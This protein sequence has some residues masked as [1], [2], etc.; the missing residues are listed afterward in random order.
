MKTE[1]EYKQEIEKLGKIILDLNEK[2]HQK[3]IELDSLYWVWCSGGCGGGVHRYKHSETLTE[4][5]VK[6]AEWNTKRLRTWWTN[7]YIDRHMSEIDNIRIAIRV[8]KGKQQKKL[9]KIGLHHWMD[10]RLHKTCEA[11]TVICTR[12]FKKDLIPAPHHMD[13]IG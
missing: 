6:R 1:E 2:L 13:M 9:C 8:W 4:E 11:H 12:C 5:I 3:N 7:S 10:T